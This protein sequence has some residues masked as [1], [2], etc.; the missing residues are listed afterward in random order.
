MAFA[1]GSC[2][3]DRGDFCVAQRAI[4]NFYFVDLADEVTRLARDF[5]SD[6]DFSVRRLNGKCADVGR[7]DLDTVDVDR[8]ETGRTVIRHRDVTE[9]IEWN[10]AAGQ[11]RLGKRGAGVPMNAAKRLKRTA[12]ILYPERVR[13]RSGTG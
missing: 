9:T 10:A 6:R 13:I 7:V 3:V 11:D 4:E 8:K 5:V 12:A 1:N 2:V